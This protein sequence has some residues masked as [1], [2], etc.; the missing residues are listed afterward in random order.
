MKQFNIII[1]SLFSA[2]VA[3]PVLAQDDDT[4]SEEIKVVKKEKKAVL[5]TYPTKEIKGICVD[6][7][8]KAPLSGIM[9]QALGHANYT[10]MTEDN[11][12][13]VIKV[14]VFATALYVH[15]PQYLSQQVAIGND[16]KQLRI[17]MLADKFRPM[18]TTQTDIT[19]SNTQ[20]ITNTTSQTID[21][22]IEGLMG[23]DVRA[24]TRS[25]GPGYGAAMFI[26]GLNSLTANAQSLI[27][28]DGVV[29]DM[30][31]TRST[32]HDGDYANLL[33]NINPE[34]I[35][36]V[37]VLKNATALYGARGGNGV[38]LIETKRGH[39][40]A[41]RIDANIGVGVSMQPRL[42]KVMNA[43][44]YR[45]Y[46]SEML[47]TYPTIS[48]FKEADAFKFL[49]DDP[50]K[51]YYAM[52]HNDTDWSKEVYRTAMTQNYNI[53]VQGG[54]NIGMY[55]L[56]LG[57]TDG[58][59]TAKENGFNRLNVRFNT[60]INI[61]NHLSTRFDMSYT[62]VNRDVFD[63]GAPEDFTTGPVSSPTFLALIKSPFL[64]PYTFNNVTHRFSST[65]SNAD[66][67]LTMLDQDLSLGNPT[68]ILDNGNGINKNRFESTHFN[69]VIAPRYEINRYLTLTETFSYTLDR[70][71]QRYYR[72]AGGMPTF[73]IDGIGRVQNMAMS[74]FSKET[75]ISS[76]T[77]LQFEKQ[78]G[79]HY[80]NAFVGARLLSFA[81]D[82]NQPEGQYKSAA[83]DQTPNISTNMDFYDAIG[84]NDEWRSL[85]WTITIVIAIMFR[86]H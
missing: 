27:V 62:K 78:F 15:T 11:G 54:D 6:A 26:R 57:Y 68:A 63:N 77:R 9:V 52:Y 81:F 66:D 5:P 44:D 31:Q 13:F 32:L 18:Y 41:T 48:Q 25:G 23:A 74:M 37:T 47:G 40:M 17:E 58:Q 12:E 20:S 30:Q 4:D 21:S 1:L 42:P 33:L 7:A 84:A 45:I 38:I 65:L 3:M 71:S 16:G 85:A 79:A 83:N 34:D 22:D 67:F 50:S 72:P 28:I 53:N 36:K 69:A 55:N 64:N 43:S 10:A 29:Q 24:I 59:S 73:L 76:D 82:N 8:T 35:D 39:S 80:L 60:D 86:L 14:P 49:V 19:A 56:S 70:I 75:S 46:A 51:Y 61:I 2:F